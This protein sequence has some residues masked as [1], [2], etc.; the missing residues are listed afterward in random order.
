MRTVFG[1][2]LAVS[3]LAGCVPMVTDMWLV[4]PVSGQVYAADSGTALAEATVSNLHQAG[5]TAT[6][7]AAGEFVIEG[8]SEVQFHM[9]MPASYLDRQFWVVRHSAYADGVFVTTS[10][11]PPR[12]RQPSLVEVPMFSGLAADPDNCRFGHYRLRL[13]RFL[14]AEGMLD[15][16]RLRALTELDG[17]NCRDDALEQQWRELLEQLYRTPDPEP[18]G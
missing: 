8:Q 13:G 3:L 4:Q 18:R 5:L 1:L 15:E 7:G 16:G 2:A 12:S 11:A 14:R 17:L 6:S 9:A 10:L